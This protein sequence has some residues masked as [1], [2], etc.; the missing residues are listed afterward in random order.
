MA[1]VTAE[2]KRTRKA[3]RD[4]AADVETIYAGMAQVEQRIKPGRDLHPTYVRLQNFET[5]PNVKIILTQLGMCGLTKV[6]AVR[7]YVDWRP[8]GRQV[9]HGAD[10]DRVTGLLVLRPGTAEKHDLE[11][12]DPLTGGFVY[13][14]WEY[15][16][17]YEQTEPLVGPVRRRR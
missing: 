7:S 12:V 14:R 5:E 16:Y 6:T 17:A 8:L 4:R 15:V 11:V 1:T 3:K 10:G 2:K 9:R 13:Y